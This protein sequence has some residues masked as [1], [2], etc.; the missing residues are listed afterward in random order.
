MLAY[1]LSEHSLC[2]SKNNSRGQY[3]ESVSRKGNVTSHD[4][5]NARDEEDEKAKEEEDSFSH[6]SAFI[7]HAS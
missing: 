7:M 3:L 6:M 1:E 5:D 2:W 4:R